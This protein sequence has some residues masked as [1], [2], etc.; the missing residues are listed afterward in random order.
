MVQYVPQEKDKKKGAGDEAE[1]EERERRGRGNKM[2]KS[3]EKENE[4]F[5]KRRKHA[6][7]LA[8]LEVG[9]WATLLHEY[10][11]ETDKVREWRFP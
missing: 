11:K 8:K 2:K 6:E 7:R 5:A 1:K 3:K 10:L 9:D 4:P